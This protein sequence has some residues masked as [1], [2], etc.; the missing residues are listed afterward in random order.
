MAAASSSANMMPD[1]ERAVDEVLGHRLE[2]SAR[3]FDNDIPCLT[4]ATPE[5]RAF[6]SL[7][8]NTSS[9]PA[10]SHPSSAEPASPGPNPFV[11]NET[12]NRHQ[13]VILSPA[14]PQAL[15][16]ACILESTTSRDQK[17]SL[18]TLRGSHLEKEDRHPIRNEH[19]LENNV[20][21][22][23]EHACTCDL[24]TGVGQP[25]VTSTDLGSGLSGSSSTVTDPGNHKTERREGR[26]MEAVTGVLITS[27]FSIA[28]LRMMRRTSA[29]CQDLD[30]DRLPN[31]ILMH[32]LSFLE[33]CDL[34]ATSRTNHHLRSL[35]LLPI[36][37][38]YR[39]RR[40]R[41]SLSSL[42]VSPSRPTLAELIARHIFLT[43]TTQISRRLARSLVTIKLSRRLPLRPSAE[44]LVQR[45]VL[46]GEVVG[47]AV[48]PALVAQRRAVERERLKDSLRRWVGGKWRGEVRE[49]G[50]G[51]RRW[52]ESRG[53]GR[54]WRLRRFWERVGGDG[55]GGAVERAFESSGGRGL[56]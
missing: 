10:P 9:L 29:W 11:G 19:S 35:S 23:D 40:V 55:G 14:D 52:D 2:S 6:D 33:V 18:A 44:S 22:Q 1:G 36:L 16:L 39:L 3:R 45:G 20:I 5:G 53:V 12:I 43:H 51:V 15:R 46:P 8:S 38:H 25:A 7:G 4:L 28:R 24:H 50:E 42:L 31:E 17:G 56:F 37:H 49:R 21:H 54:V 32:I 27:G 26:M 30:L 41:I 34:L 47:G 13:D 48:A